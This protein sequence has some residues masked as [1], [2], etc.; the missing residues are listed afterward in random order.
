M[1]A[2]EIR[3]DEKLQSLVVRKTDEWI[4]SVTPMI[5]NDRVLLTS[6]HQYQDSEYPS[7]VGGW[8][9][10]K[11]GSAV[12]AA[13]AWNPDTEDRP[14]GFKKEAVNSRQEIANERR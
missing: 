11:G 5:F 10:D 3:F 8:C 12:L 2:D 4:V 14:V 7:P 13:L 6:Q 1:N 9:Y